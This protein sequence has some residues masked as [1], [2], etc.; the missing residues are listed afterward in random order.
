MPSR[1]PSKYISLILAATILGIIV[2]FFW[3]LSNAG[4][5]LG[6]ETVPVV[7]DHSEAQIELGRKLFFDKRLSI[8]NTVS[9]VS[10]HDPK[11]AFTDGKKFS[12][13]VEGRLGFRNAPTLLNVID[14]TSFMFDAE[15]KT[16]EEQAIVPIQDHAEMDISM[17]DLIRKL[18]SIPEYNER[19]QEIFNK[20]FD[21]SVL[22][23]SLAAF[24]KTLISKNSLFDQFLATGDSSLLNKLQLKGWSKFNKYNCI[25][26]HE[27]PNLTDYQPYNIG[28]YV[29][30]G[31]DQGRFRVTHDSTD[32][33]KFKTPTLRNIELTA[34]YFHD[35]SAQSLSDVFQ[36]HIS[37]SKL[38]PN[39]DFRLRDI[40]ITPVEEKELIE[41]LKIVTDTDFLLNL[42]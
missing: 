5:S 37:G 6:S 21:A 34:P 9:C 31:E 19:S 11:R 40:Q 36:S 2:L 17:G 24:Q 8:D 30:Y 10:C 3:L 13:G 35:G 22:T 28:L 12:E 16:L 39:K 1:K 33:G 18:R 41:F 42:P 23:R 27:L 25:E 14:A 26:C 20:E 32:M 15:I 29:D 7:K 4:K 38:H